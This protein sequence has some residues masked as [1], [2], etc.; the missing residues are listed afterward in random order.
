MADLIFD[1]DL[2]A[3]RASVARESATSLDALGDRLA[4]L[5]SRNYFGCGCVEG[6]RMFTLLQSLLSAGVGMLQDAA[7][8]ASNISELTTLGGRILE[9][10][11]GQT[12][13]FQM[14]GK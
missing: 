4:S 2:W 14:D 7:S 13:L 12:G 9:T 6:E 5:V 11:D 10:S 1:P 8:A 3:R